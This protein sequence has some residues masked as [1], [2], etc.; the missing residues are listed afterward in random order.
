[1]RLLGRDGSTLVTLEWS[2]VK[3]LAAGRLGGREAIAVMS[4]HQVLIL[5]SAGISEIALAAGG[6]GRVDS[7]AIGRFGGQDTLVTAQDNNLAIFNLADGAEI[8]RLNSRHGR[9][10]ATAVTPI[11]GR[12]AIVSAGA[13]SILRIWESDGDLI[14]LT[15]LSG[16]DGPID[17]LAV[18]RLGS[19]RGILTGHRDG[20]ALLWSA[21]DHRRA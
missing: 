8:A 4:R 20:T 7:I 12:Q 9:V 14:E 19:H 6:L 21:R 1:V 18:G 10:W 11:A 17:S 3:R 5:Q 15:E 16:H 2:G 13:D